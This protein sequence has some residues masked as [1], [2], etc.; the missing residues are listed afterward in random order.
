MPVDVKCQTCRYWSQ[1]SER[2]KELRMG[3]CRRS[4][5]RWVDK[6]TCAFP[7]TDEEQACGEYYVKL[8]LGEEAAKDGFNSP[9]D[10]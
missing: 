2:L 5:P 1:P 3:V 9:F 10:S 8:S 6:E 7:S 4:P